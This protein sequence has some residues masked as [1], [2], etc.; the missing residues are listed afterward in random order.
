S[1]VMSPRIMR[2]VGENCKCEASPKMRPTFGV[3]QRRIERLEEAILPLPPAPP[4]VV[5]IQIVDSERKV[6]RT[7]TFELA[8]VRPSGRLWRTARGGCDRR[9]LVNQR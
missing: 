1:S 8:Q 7:K 6:V 3:R 5:T 2:H 4:E 9:R